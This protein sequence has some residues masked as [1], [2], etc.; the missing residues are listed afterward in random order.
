MQIGAGFTKTTKESNRTYIS[1]V[2]NKELGIINPNLYKLLE[3]C[4]IS[5]YFV[6]E[7][8]RKNDKSPS[9]IVDISE[10]EKTVKKD[11]NQIENEIIGEREIP[12]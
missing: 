11:K 10:K 5:L 8:E 2:L 12:F 4:F 3:N 1:I 7:D 9:W 6:P